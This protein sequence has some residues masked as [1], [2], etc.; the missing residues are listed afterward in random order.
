V[1]IVLDSSVLIAAHIARAGVCSELLEDVLIQHQLVVSEYI[2]DE[3]ARKLTDKFDFPTSSVRAIVKSLAGTAITVEPASVPPGVCR[4]P[5]DLAVLGTALAGEADLLIT[6]EKD[7]LELGKF[8]GTDIIK[9]GA[10]WR[11]S[12][13]AT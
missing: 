9:P 2:L 3:L 10:F 8:R 6:V 11:R 4:D 7:L 12:E 1:R 13:N 5:N